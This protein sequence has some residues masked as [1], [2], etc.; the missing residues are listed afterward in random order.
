LVD[1]AARPA[2]VKNGDA[3]SNA[4][5][6]VHCCEGVHNTCIDNNRGN[7]VHKAHRSAFGCVSPRTPPLRKP[8]FPFF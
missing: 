4:F 2:L 8:S 6:R 1:L 5:A 7:Y 3:L